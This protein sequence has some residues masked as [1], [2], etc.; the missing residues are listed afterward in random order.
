MMLCSSSRACRAVAPG[1]RRP[2]AVIHTESCIV[3]AERSREWT[4]ISIAI[5]TQK[6]GLMIVAP[7]KPA[8]ATPTTV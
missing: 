8:S 4:C 2:I 1:L 6:S 3:S 5:G 7:V